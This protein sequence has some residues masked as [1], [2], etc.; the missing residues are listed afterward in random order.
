M[1]TPL[2][3]ELRSY[4]NNSGNETVSTT[5]NGSTTILQNSTNTNGYIYFDDSY[6][7]VPSVSKYSNSDMI[8]YT[9]NNKI[10]GI[11]NLHLFNSQTATIALTYTAG[12]YSKRYLLNKSL[13]ALEHYFSYSTENKKAIITWNNHTSSAPSI[14]SNKYERQENQWNVSGLSI[15]SFP[16][17]STAT[18]GIT[19]N[20]TAKNTFGTA[21]V[22]TIGSG[23][24]DSTVYNFIYDKPSVDFYNSLS[25]TLKNA[26]QII[27]TDSNAPG[28]YNALGNT[29]DSNQLNMWNGWFY[30]KSGWI[31]STGISTTNCSNYGLS[32]SDV[33]FQGND[34][35]Y[36][37]V[38]FEYS[39]TAVSGYTPFG[40][41]V[42]FGDNA[43]FKLSDIAGGVYGGKTDI[44]LYLFIQ[45]YNIILTI[46]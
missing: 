31:S 24:E 13:N 18:V 5:A 14:S 10:N 35:D 8:S 23:D 41:F 19:L 32:T 27:S 17:T 15:T 6:T 42:V 46:T 16:S 1:Y 36:K 25:T 12:G 3:Y 29:T 45:S 7:G 28:N 40:G 20:I 33:M 43:D 38:I 30:S 37:F 34:S 11:P 21:S 44:K 22:K 4:Y 26:K 2:K 9:T 39:Y